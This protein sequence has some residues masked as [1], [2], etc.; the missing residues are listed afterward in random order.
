[1]K[2]M[3]V[4]VLW[5]LLI[6]LV[7]CNKLEPE[8]AVKPLEVSTKVELVKNNAS[9]WLVEDMDIRKRFEILS[10]QFTD[11]NDLLKSKQYQNFV[12]YVYTV[13][14]KYREKWKIDNPALD[15]LNDKVIT[16]IVY[17]WYVKNSRLDWAE[18]EIIV[19]S[20]RRNKFNT[21]NEKLLLTEKF[22]IR[23]E[24]W[25]YNKVIKSITSEKIIDLKHNDELLKKYLLDSNEWLFYT[26]LSSRYDWNKTWIWY[27]T[28]SMETEFMNY[29]HDKFH[30]S[31][32]LSWLTPGYIKEKIYWFNWYSSLDDQAKDILTDFHNIV[33]KYNLDKNVP[34][35]RYYRN[36][37]RSVIF[38]NRDSINKY[39][40]LISWSRLKEFEEDLKSIRL[41]V[42]MLSYFWRNSELNKD[43]WLW[44][45]R[46]RSDFIDK[47]YGKWVQNLF[48][49]W[50]YLS[51]E[52][53]K[54]DLF[55]DLNI[56]L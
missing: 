10:M 55:N 2:N 48:R 8:T 36:D 21:L 7:S 34:L 49:L 38:E 16:D 42:Y 29:L 1:M 41:K 23:F 47:E 35:T 3:K 14:E 37:E 30:K 18:A 12:W 40:N 15:Y 50:R 22:K 13:F 31:L 4:I 39:I 45:S 54:I 6:T 56:N 25:I 46:T 11:Y 44:S 33:K 27:K 28:T 20:I 51:D 53:I 5:L 32:S 19:Q 26:I 17:E 24:E 9:H 43:N 52:E